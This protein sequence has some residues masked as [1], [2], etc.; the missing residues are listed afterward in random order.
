MN[1]SILYLGG[2]ELPDKNAAAQRVLSN[3][4]LLRELGFDVYFMGISKDIDKAPRIVNGFVSNPI[5][6]AQSIKQ[7]MHQIL[8]FID[9]KI[10]YNY[11]PDYVVL[12]NFPAV[13]SLR[14]LKACHKNGIKVIHD[15][16]E[17]EASKGYSLRTIIRKLDITLRMHYC[18]PK[19][20]GV[21]AISR[22]LYDYYK[23]YTKVILVPPLINLEADKWKRN[24]I[25]SSGEK[26]RLVYAGNAGFGVKDRLDIIVESVK[27]HHTM[28]LDIIGMTKEDY[29]K[30]YGFFPEECDNIVFHGRVE[31][32]KAIDAVQNA[33]F[34][35]LIRDDNLKNKAGF[36]TKFVES[37]ACCTPVIATLTSN[38]GD[39]LQD[40]KNGF[41]V[42]TN[43]NLDCVLDSIS[44]LS[45]E[46]IVKMKEFCKQITDFDYREYKSDFKQLFV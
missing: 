27:Q 4:M 18:I 41:I 22:Y 6:Y 38:I 13:A 7:W 9:T 8:S 17:W 39:Y 12:Y 28:Q 3:A 24:R 42:D 33:D 43:R 16:T 26:V 44:N 5:P 1:K 10:I 25:L 30:G 46:R 37:M 34:Q 23:Q 29:V 45:S 35:F 2:F 20:D 31:H 36:P 15:I 19:M 11:N 21:I 32:T 14:I 40:G